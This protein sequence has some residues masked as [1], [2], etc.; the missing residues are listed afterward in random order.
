MCFL[1][2]EDTGIVINLRESNKN[3]QDDFGTFWDK[4]NE[5]L[6]LVVEQKHSIMSFMAKTVS[7]RDLI[8]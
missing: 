3:G 7:V 2:M 5:F 6:L 8:E 1:A 4:C